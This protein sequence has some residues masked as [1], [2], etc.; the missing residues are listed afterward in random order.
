MKQTASTEI[1]NPP[2]DGGNPSAPLAYSAAASLTELRH[3]F[4]LVYGKYRERQLV[5]ES[6]GGV[7]FS[8]QHLLPYAVTLAGKID[9]TVFTTLS[10]VMDGPL[11][12][13]LDAVFG[14]ELNRL[15]RDGAV[16]GELGLFADRRRS[17]TQS[18]SSMHELFRLGYW[19]GRSNS[20]DFGVIGVH[21]RHAAFYQRLFGFRTMGEVR[22]HPTVRNAPAILLLIEEE[23][24]GAS[25]ERSKYVRQWLQNPVHASVWEQRY[26]PSI[27]D[28]MALTT[29]RGQPEM[30]DQLL[31]FYR[32]AAQLAEEQAAASEPDQPQIRKAG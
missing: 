4:S 22:E 14:D 2:A 25:A 8:R 31:P 11:G 3:C 17:L 30:L 28:V 27:P 26:R 19:Y 10:V 20:A 13:P 7:F 12:L 24:I 9:Q 1:V 29:L 6:G 23:R 16:L 21:P 5:E 32:T 18:L 15:R